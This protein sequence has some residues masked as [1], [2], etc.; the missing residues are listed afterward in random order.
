MSLVDIALKPTGHEGDL[1]NQQWAAIHQPHLAS[2]C[3]NRKEF[4]LP[5][6]HIKRLIKEESTYE[7]NHHFLKDKAPE[8][9]VSVTTFRK[10]WKKLE[11][12][13]K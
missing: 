13:S 4:V 10:A 6:S 1:T 7:F 12:G 11:G 3:I 5:E 8:Y 9:G 2:N